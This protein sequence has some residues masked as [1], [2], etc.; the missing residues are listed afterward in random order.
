MSLQSCLRMEKEPLDQ[1]LVSIFFPHP[2]SPEVGVARFLGLTHQFRVSG[3]QLPTWLSTGV[4]MRLQQKLHS[5]S[6]HRNETRCKS[7]P[8]QR[9]C[10]D[11]PQMYGAP[12]LYPV[13]S[14]LSTMLW[15][16]TCHLWILL[17]NSSSLHPGITKPHL[18]TS[19]FQTLKT[20]KS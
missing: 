1:T 8:G 18:W 17:S 7:S 19:G 16:F 15:H 10:W 20:W 11:L 12:K 3:C 14:I 9:P 5:I 13:C 2:R 4:L 6:M